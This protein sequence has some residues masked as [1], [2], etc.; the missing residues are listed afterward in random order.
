MCKKR[1]GYVRVSTQTQR[2][3]R[4]IKN[5]LDYA[6]EL[7]IEKIYREKFTG[8]K[9]ERPE[10]QKLLKV[11]KSGD[12]IIF[13]SVS[14]MSRDAQEGFEIYMD[15]FTKGIELVFIKEPFCNTEAFKELQ[16]KQIECLPDTGNMAVNE[17]MDSIVKAL[18]KYALEVL[19][20]QIKAVFEQSEKEVV[21]LHK[22]VS[23]GMKAS[24]RKNEELPESERKQIGRV[25]GQK[26]ET[27]KSKEM[28]RNIKKMS[29]DFEG[30]LSDKEI[31]A[32][33]KIARNSF[34]KY[35]KELLQEQG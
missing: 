10:F 22:R 26:V 23:E 7:S 3:D 33:L 11:V 17:L 6:G 4:Q 1:F 12:V 2:Y 9:V 5:I 8:T 19:K 16:K 21:D 31:L 13:D 32:I 30:N 29:K 14:R 18:N 28:K 27:K 20:Q 24:Q 25:A 34:Y 15:L 35:K